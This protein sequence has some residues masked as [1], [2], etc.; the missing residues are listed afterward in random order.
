M[1]LQLSDE[2]IK[3]GAV[4]GDIDFA[5]AARGQVGTV[6]ALFCRAGKGDLPALTAKSVQQCQHAIACC[7]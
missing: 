3:A 5:D 7:T 1:K 6:D 4:E 2:V